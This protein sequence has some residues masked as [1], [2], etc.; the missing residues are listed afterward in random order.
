[1]CGGVLCVCVCVC[2]C[3]H[4]QSV[5]FHTTCAPSVPQT[6]AG[7]ALALDIIASDCQARQ[8][9]GDEVDLIIHHEDLQHTTTSSKN[10]VAKRSSMS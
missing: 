3:V 7:V 5:G 1:M 6:A 10:F 2:V 9:R 4:V 8:A